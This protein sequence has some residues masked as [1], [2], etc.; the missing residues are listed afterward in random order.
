MFLMIL[1]K[2]MNNKWLVLCLL[3]GIIIAVAMISSIP[4][5]TDGVLQRLL[6]KDLE[7]FQLERS[8]YPGRYHF[9]S[10]IYTFFNADN[11]VAAYRFFDDAVRNDMAA[12]IGLPVVAETN[13]L[14]VDYVFAIPEKQT[15]A[16]DVKKQFIKLETLSGLED[17]VEI[18]YGEI[19]SDEMTEGVIDVIVTE[20]AFKEKGLVLGDTYMVADIMNLVEEPLR[21]RIKGIFT[22]KDTQDPFW[23]EYLQAYSESLMLDYDLFSELFVKDKFPLLSDSQWFYAFDYHSLKIDMLP[24]LVKAHN[25]NTR[26]TAEYR[27]IELRFPASEIIEEYY[28]R[29]R[30][31]KIS[32]W[33]MQIPILLM[34]AFYLFMVSQL[35]VG[36]DLN[37]IAVLKS[38]GAST[39][40]VFMAYV[41]ESVL[42]AGIALIL[43]P[44]LGLFLCRILGASNGF[45]DFVQR[46]A[47]PVALGKRAYIYAFIAAGVSV[48]TTLVPVLIYSRISIVEYKQKKAK[49]RTALWKKFGLDLILLAVSGYGLYTYN[50]RRSALEATGAQGLDIAIDPLLFGISTAFVL[51]AGLLFVRVYPFI[52]RIISR[53]GREIWPP[54]IYASFI[55]V[56]RSRGQDSFIMLFLILSISVGLFNANAARTINTN[57]E[58]KI[59]YENGADITMMAYWQDDKPPEIVD[60]D[61]LSFMDG[62]SGSIANEDVQYKEPDFTPF[63]NLAGTQTV[64]RVFVKPSV[65]VRMLTGS[66][67][68][69]QLMGI[70]PVEFAEVG[71]FRRDLLP[72]HWYNYLNFLTQDPRAVLL[73]RSFEEDGVQI[74]DVVNIT[75]A[76]QGQLECT[77][78]AFVDYWPTFNP[79]SQKN[80]DLVVANLEYIHAKMALEP[81]EVWVKKDP[82]ATSEELYEDLENK[83][84]RV[85][86]LDDTSQEIIKAKNDPML[87]GT[88]GALTLGFVVTILICMLG[89][90]IFWI[91]SIKRR[92]LQFGILR[93]MGIGRSKIL[94]MLAIEQL[95]VSGAAVIAGIVAGGLAS[96]LFVPLLQ[97]TYA[98]SQQV[99][100]FKVV[101]KAGD[102]LKLYLSVS[103]MLA[104]G[105]TMLGILVSRIRISQAI[106]LGEE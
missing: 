101:F 46:T 30:Q 47:L 85:V 105:L 104:A 56:G 68:N 80:D 60:P 22:I 88:N 40:Q 75:W 25:E 15:G 34:L 26:W 106:K 44:L 23:F 13:K 64:T 43:G 28:Q 87:Q 33:V 51:G 42:F 31:L 27:G 58:E 39:L 35:I 73:S 52:V 86:D 12:K 94:W 7:N 83:R 100:P 50:I 97:M 96:N 76:R 1:R 18:L 38:R 102:Y 67:G 61:A 92:E 53:L 93:A 11:R 2:I 62:L 20:Q 54:V 32:L 45:L 6:T 81:Y 72:Y 63:T 55:Q 89:F 19:F 69:V 77:V 21:V 29:E 9:R 99:P 66:K 3:T 74:G 41:I 95:L 90:L 70:V 14:S 82:D 103:F 5:Y 91:L 48:V 84:L 17:H 59:K 49:K 65:N 79:H 36:S 57:I 16:E 10:N 24:G 78:Y 37:E 98:A 71:W 4:V 8:T